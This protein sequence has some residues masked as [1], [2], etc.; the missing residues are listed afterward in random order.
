MILDCHLTICLLYLF[1]GRVRCDLKNLV[2]AIVAFV[3]QE[4]KEPVDP[5]P[6]TSTS[7]ANGASTDKKPV[8]SSASNAGTTDVKP[9]SSSAK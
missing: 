2:I 8:S 4:Y 6:V 1:V 7:S 9:S 3:T 5:K